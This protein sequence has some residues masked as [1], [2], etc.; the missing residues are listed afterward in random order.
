MSF[1]AVLAAA[2][3]FLLALAHAVGV[4]L[5][6][7]SPWLVVDVVML[8]VVAFLVRSAALRLLDEGATEA[9]RWTLAGLLMAG[10]SP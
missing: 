8:V 5:R 4:A 10:S 9:W 7:R 2:A 3:V 6:A 1:A